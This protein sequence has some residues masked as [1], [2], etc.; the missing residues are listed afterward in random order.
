[1]KPNNKLK[2]NNKINAKKKAIHSP[3]R[4]H[5]QSFQSQSL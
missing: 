5:A 2:K 1:M 3:L 4:R